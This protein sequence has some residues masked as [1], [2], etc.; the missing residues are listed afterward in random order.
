M[1]VKKPYD[2]LTTTLLLDFSLDEEL[3]P[4]EDCTFE[5]EDG[6]VSVELAGTTEEELM[7]QFAKSRTYVTPSS[8]RNIFSPS[9]ELLKEVS[10]DEEERS[11]ADD[12]WTTL[13]DDE[14]KELL[15]SLA[16]DE[17]FFEDEQLDLAFDFTLELLDFLEEDETSLEEEL[18]DGP[19]ELLDF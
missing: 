3:L 7:E 10:F 6:K 18:F 11:K 5:D 1:S 4:L 19:L 2:I 13:E 17:I 16:E 9:L 15:D 14:R 12:D 8:Q